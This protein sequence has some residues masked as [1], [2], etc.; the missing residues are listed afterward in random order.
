MQALDA[1]G[2]KTSA[3][4]ESGAVACWGMGEM[5]RAAKVGLTG[6]K[7][8]SVGGF[9]NACAVADGAVYCWGNSTF[10][11]EGTGVTNGEIVPAPLSSC[12]TALC[13]WIST[14]IMRAL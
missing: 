6:I 14:A 12:Q 7:T 11:R 8:I 9:D 3:L 13:R 4:L 1:G 10:G 2:G 5:R